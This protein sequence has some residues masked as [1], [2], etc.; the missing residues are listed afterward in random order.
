MNTRIIEEEKKT[1]ALKN[2]VTTADKLVEDLKEQLTEKDQETKS[3]RLELAS[4]REKEKQ[5]SLEIKQ[6]MG[7]V[8]ELQKRNYKENLETGIVQ[9]MEKETQRKLDQLQAELDEI[10]GKQIVQMKQELI[11][12]H[13]SQLEDLRSQH[14]GEMEN[15]LKSH[16]DATVSEEQLK[17]MNVAMSELN[18]KLQD[19]LAQKEKLGEELCV[20]KGEKCALQSQ[21]D[22]L[23]EESGFLR[24]Q[25]QRARQTIAELE[26]KLSEVCKSLSTVEGLKAEIAAA[27]ETKKELELKHDAE[28]TNYK[29]KLEMLEKEKNAVLDRMA[30]SQEAELERLRTQLLFSHEEEL[31]KLKG[32]LEAAHRLNMEKL[33]DNLGIHHK[34]QIDGLQ[35]EMSQ[36][37]E[38]M[39]CEKDNLLTKQN[40]LLLEIS[41]LRDLQESRINSKSEEMTLQINELKK[42]IEILK[43]EEK[44][45]GALEQEIQELQLKTELLKEQLKEKEEVLQEKCA[46]LEAENS[47]LTDEKTALEDMLKSY[48]PIDQVER[49]SA[50]KDHSWQEE[51][52]ILRKEKEDLIQQCSHLNKEIENQRN[53]FSFAEKNFEVNY[54]ELQEEYAC[55]LRVKDDL[56]DIQAR[57]ALEYEDRIKA[58]TQE[59]LLQ[60]GKHS[61]FT[62]DRAFVAEPLE[63]S[64]VVEK[65]TTE[66]MEKLK[67]TE[68]EKVELSEKLSVVSEQL[69]QTRDEVDSLSAEVRLLNQDKE[70]LL[71]RCRALEVPTD[72]KGTENAAECPVPL[73]SSKAG[74]VT[75][76]DSHHEGCGSQIS[77]DL[78]E[79]SKIM[80]E[81]KIP[82]KESRGEELILLT[83]TTEPTHGM[84]EPCENEKLQQE[85]CIL[86]VKQV[87]PCVMENPSENTHCTLK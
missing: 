72:P 18:I 50:L 32:D 22:D 15:T 70:Q 1:A 68:R 86:K 40:Q 87:C 36:K 69:K 37:M 46:Q 5:C 16:A 3:F 27:S 13:M 6:L 26:S 24:E 45:K 33:K 25:I 34:Q 10:Y 41:E 80:I 35:N 81:D 38:T 83:R 64:E 77:E 76:T 7:A 39:Q 19:T 61:D 54:Q 31:C 59:L 29:I 51:V 65:D 57:Q 62:D 49:V 47:I 63:V 20:V 58:L 11:K 56:E 84:V 43:Q 85:L 82:F 75:V 48:T 44:E 17:L 71:L 74:L 78:P 52:E 2:K 60:K 9:R 8:E 21:F 12:Q 73:S 55:L 66:L 53:T 79:E 28:I 42:E 67:V 30:E 14:K 4:S 23:S